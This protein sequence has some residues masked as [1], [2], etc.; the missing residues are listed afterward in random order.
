MDRRQFLKQMSSLAAALSVAPLAQNLHANTT[1]INTAPI[2][3]DK[4]GK[5][6]PQRQLGNTGQFITALGLGGAHMGGAKSEADAQAICETAIEHGIRFIDTAHAYQN[7]RSETRIGKYL[8]KYRDQLYL[9]SKT[10][11]Y[12]GKQARQQL[13]NS[14]RRLKTDVIDCYHIHTIENPT[15]VDKRLDN[16]VLDTLLAARE[17]GQIRHIGFSCHKRTAAPLRMLERLEAMGIDLDAC[18]LALNACDPH[19]DSF[20]L[21]VLPKVIE[22]GYGVFA[23]KTL[24]NG[25]FFG[26]IDGWARQGRKTPGEIIPARMSLDQALNY[27]WSLPICTLISGMENPQQVKQNAELCRNYQLPTDDEINQLVAA[28]QDIAGTDMEFYKN[29]PD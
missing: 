7:G 8:A 11:S 13:D 9:M 29:L 10:W 21:R 16:G 4:W 15:D 24:A 17:K 5:L 19:Y 6:L 12:N 27:V 1:P 23:M 2:T 26:R 22:K 18:Q 28:T 20:A 14:L 25:Q 3:E